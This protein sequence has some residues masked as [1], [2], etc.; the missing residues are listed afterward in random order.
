MARMNNEKENGRSCVFCDFSHKS[1]KCNNYS[2]KLMVRT[3][4]KLDFIRNGSPKTGASPVF[5][6]GFWFWFINHVSLP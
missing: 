4:F 1:D 6:R 3:C 5:I 2:T